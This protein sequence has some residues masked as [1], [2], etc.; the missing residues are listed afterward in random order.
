MEFLKF[1]LHIFLSVPW[2]KHNSFPIW[3]NLTPC[4][5]FWKKWI[6]TW[7][8]YEHSLWLG[9]GQ[10]SW[11]QVKISSKKSS[12][13]SFFLSFLLLNGQNN[14]NTAV[15]LLSFQV[16]KT[17]WWILMDSGKLRKHVKMCMKSVFYKKGNACYNVNI[18]GP[19]FVLRYGLHYYFPSFNSTK[20][21]FCSLKLLSG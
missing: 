16:K 7:C 5:S 12:L 11:S 1:A 21:E 2:E 13:C 20:K 9:L 14:I 10:V 3:R 18:I 15:S 19:Y 17:L 8:F 4:L 6:H